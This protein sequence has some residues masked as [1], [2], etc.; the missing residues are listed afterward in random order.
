[1]VEFLFL[2]ARLI[3]HLLSLKADE[4]YFG[5]F[6]IAMSSFLINLWFSMKVDA[7]DENRFENNIKSSMSSVQMKIPSSAH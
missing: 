7:Y 6:S 4:D 1:M 3:Q 5:E 2:V